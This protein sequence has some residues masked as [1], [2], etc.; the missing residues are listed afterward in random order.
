MHDKARQVSMHVFHMTFL[1]VLKRS[2]HSTVERST[3]FPTDR[4]FAIV[5]FK[6]DVKWNIE[7]RAV[8]IFRVHR[9]YSAS[10]TY[11][12]FK[13]TP[14]KHAI[15]KNTTFVWCRLFKKSR[16]FLENDKGDRRRSVK[17]TSFDVIP[18]AH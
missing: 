10:E 11:K 16:E 4:I 13:D 8:I 17:A 7:T 9:E 2:Y 1:T 15:Y 18:S 6:H 14:L 5:K 3:P 12:M